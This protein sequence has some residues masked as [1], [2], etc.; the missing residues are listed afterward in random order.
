MS[1]Q[2]AFNI[3]GVVLAAMALLAA[4]H[5][6]REYA[7]SD[8]ADTRVLLTFAFVP[9]RFTLLY[10]RAG[11]VEAFDQFNQAA[12]ALFFLGD[13]AP[14]WW[15]LVT[16]GF[17]HG[18]WTHLG[19]NVLWLAAFG[20][21]LARRFGAPRFVAFCLG[22]TVVG[23]LAHYVLHRYDCLPMIGASAAISGLTAA[24]LRFIFQPHGPL[25]LEQAAPDDEAY[26]QPALSLRSVFTNSRAVSF[27]VL[28]FGVN[29][30][31]GVMS[32]TLGLSQGPVAWEAHVGGFV[33]GLLLF[34][35]MDPP[36]LRSRM[37]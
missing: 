33:G 28:W 11:L 5:G 4:I 22:A 7:M 15:T 31:F 29:F 36:R 35:L 16:Y 25:G 21:P 24:C 13:G 10:D 8:E 27:L 17:F 2:P 26:R 19:V 34:S 3:P 37:V 30:L 14:Q 6:L 9:G 1:R 12:A 23:A 32:P 20:A 18:D